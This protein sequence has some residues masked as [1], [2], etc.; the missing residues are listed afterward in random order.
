MNALPK[1]GAGEAAPEASL[2]DREGRWVSL[3]G[4]WRGGPLVLIFLRH[5]G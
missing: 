1:V 4:F 3:S 5:L 2:E